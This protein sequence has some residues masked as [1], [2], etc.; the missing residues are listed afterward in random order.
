MYLKHLSQFEDI[1][2]ENRKLIPLEFF[3]NKVNDSQIEEYV[4]ENDD[5]EEVK[6]ESKNGVGK[7]E[8]FNIFRSEEEK[9]EKPLTEA[10]NNICV[11]DESSV[12]ISPDTYNDIHVFHTESPVER[13]KTSQESR[14]SKQ[15]SKPESAK[16]SSSEIVSN[17]TKIN[18]VFNEDNNCN[19][20][21]NN[22][23][24][25][26]DKTELENEDDDYS[27]LSRTGS[28]T[29]SFEESSF[30]DDELNYDLY[31][32]T[33]IKTNIR[34]S[35]CTSKLYKEGRSINQ[36]SEDSIPSY[37]NSNQSANNKKSNFTSLFK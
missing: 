27:S 21:V 34:S 17:F 22:Y 25:N 18:S 6:E 32:K 15:E 16:E 12:S 10:F 7:G 1:G 23:N 29:D 33:I 37:R 19:L 30:S 14:N 5:L 35:N 26:I 24:Y 11:I 3:K 13:I 8:E 28:F 2:E 31:L 20:I 4:L 36:S 9:D